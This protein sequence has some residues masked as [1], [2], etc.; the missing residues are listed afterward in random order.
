ME[1]VSNFLTYTFQKNTVVLA[2]DLLIKTINKLV[3]KQVASN[4]LT[5]ASEL[6]ESKVRKNTF[7]EN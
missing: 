1:T 2:I 7:G 4:C 3:L 5:K 6:I